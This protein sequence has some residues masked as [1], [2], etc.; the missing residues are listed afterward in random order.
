MDCGFAGNDREKESVVSSQNPGGEN[1]SPLNR[2]EEEEM[3]IRSNCDERVRY[4]GKFI[5]TPDS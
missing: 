1:F 3:T 4:Q 5:L 2:T